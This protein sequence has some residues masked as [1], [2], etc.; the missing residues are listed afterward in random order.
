MSYRLLETSATTAAMLSNYVG[1][2]RLLPVTDGDR[3]F[4]EWRG[5]YDVH[6]DPEEVRAMIEQYVYLPCIR[7]LQGL[8]R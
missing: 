4:I 3:T 5:E 2:V 1:Q 6:G 8:V 7:G